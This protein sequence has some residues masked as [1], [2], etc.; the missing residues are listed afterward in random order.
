MILDDDAKLESKDDRRWGRRVDDVAKLYELFLSMSDK[1]DR[2]SDRLTRFEERSDQHTRNYERLVIEQQEY[3]RML[4]ERLAKQ[5]GRILVLEQD[6]LRRQIIDTSFWKRFEKLIWVLVAAMVGAGVSSA[7][8][9]KNV[10]KTQSPPSAS[11]P[12]RLESAKNE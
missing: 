7:I 9:T 10:A 8:P 3:Q 6:L 2:I 1:L 5:E 12:S 11:S 4:D